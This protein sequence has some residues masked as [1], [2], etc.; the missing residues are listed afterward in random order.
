MNYED[1]YQALTPDEKSLKETIAALTRLQ[2]TIVRETESGDLK[3]LSRDLKTIAQTAAALSAT[4]E[5]LSNSVEGFDSRAYFE[6]G[7]FAAQMLDI[8]HEQ[9]VDVQG[10]FPVYKMFPY[11]VKIDVENQDVYLDKKR[12]QCMRPSS[13]VKTVKAS[14]EKLQKVRFNAESYADELADTYDLALLKL[15]KKPGSVLYLTS[16]YKFLT[17]MG[18]F[19]RE[20]DMQGFSYDISRLYAEYVKGNRTSKNGRTFDFGP[21][22]NNS[23]GIRILDANGNEQ[24]LATIS[25]DVKK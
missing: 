23:K 10:E 25:F 6:D 11:K 9:N 15:N 5:K 4:I 16:L 24:F 8:C 19:R 17:P 20:Y 7:D 13:F 21:A 12:I 1:L 22:H 18:R 3:Y 2:K 14:Q